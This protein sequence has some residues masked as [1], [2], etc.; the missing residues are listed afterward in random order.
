MYKIYCYPFLIIIKSCKR[1]F[2]KNCPNYLFEI[3][4]FSNFKIVLNNGKIE[5]LSEKSI[6]KKKNAFLNFNDSLVEKIMN[7]TFIIHEDLT[8]M[9]DNFDDNIFHDLASN[10]T[11]F[12]KNCAISLKKTFKPFFETLGK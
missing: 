10:V 9:I 3:S 6:S 11:K 12:V 1:I 5:F 8:K 7:I 4:I 2:E